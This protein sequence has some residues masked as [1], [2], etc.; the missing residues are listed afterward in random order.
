MPNLGRPIRIAH[1]SDL[2]ASTVVPTS[3]IEEA[4]AGAIEFDPD[5]ICVTGDFVTGSAG[6]NTVWYRSVLR[7]LS[8]NAPTFAV[9]GNHD[10]GPWS[11][12]GGGFPT[13]REV[14]ELLEQSGI[15]VLNNRSRVLA[16]GGRPL[17]LAGVGDLWSGDVRP[18]LAFA[19]AD[20]GLP[21]VLLAHNPDTK[22]VVSG[23]SWDLM[24]SGHTH[25]GQ[26]VVPGIGISPAPVWDRNYVS[27]LK[28][29]RGRWI[30][31]SR[32]VGNHSG[33][34]FNCRP[35]VTHLQLEP[36]GGRV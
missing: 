32:G 31:V 21:T 35:E 22:S 2:H 36:G 19:D 24:L 16:I 33:V 29:W 27:G 26:V 30:H 13:T 4:V 20:P 10:G 12:E 6:F 11:L 8:A 9:F 14:A 34:R 23:N 5:V 28:K 3:L 15:E 17:Q 1:L 7:R 18:E 25:G